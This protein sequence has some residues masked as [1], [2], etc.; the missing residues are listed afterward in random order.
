[1]VRNVLLMAVAVLVIARGVAASEL[2][3]VGWVDRVTPVELVLVC[4]AM[5]L[6]V[7]VAGLGWFCLELLQQNGR[8]LARMDTLEERFRVPGVPGAAAGERGLNGHG[9]HVGLPLGA[10]APGFELSR[11]GG[12]LGGLSGLLERSLPVL[13]VFSDPGCGPCNALVP[14]IAA[15]QREHRN[16]LTVAVVSRGSAEAN[17][18]KTKEHGLSDVFLQAD[19]EV[20][21]SY[22]AH[23]TPCGVVID[24]KGMIQSPVAAGAD[25]ISALVGRAV[26]GGLEVLQVLRPGSGPPTST[27]P[28]S[29]RGLSVGTPAPDLE[30][31]E[32]HGGAVSLRDVGGSTVVLFWNPRCGFCDRLLPELKAW[33]R[34]RDGDDPNLIVISTGTPAENDALTLSSPVIVEAGFET[35]QAFGASGT[36]SA[37]LIDE[38]GRVASSVAVGGPNVMALLK[39]RAR[40]PVEA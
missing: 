5:L 31:A 27:A 40:A 17:A 11:V 33:E 3:P 9:P 22:E 6:V 10:V 18:D 14:D 32:I 21:Q 30:W 1:M 25:A 2:S 28:P 13:L 37:V 29:G 39:T 7:V 15:W 4:V 38:T 35:G 24:A 26:G 36:P 20:A 34:G 19:R 23:G 12:G 16:R 8:I